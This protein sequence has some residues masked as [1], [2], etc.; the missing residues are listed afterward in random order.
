MKQHTQRK[1]DN[2]KNPVFI[3]KATWMNF[4]QT[5]DTSG[6]VQ[7]HPNEVWLKYS[8]STSEQ[9]S[10]LSL[11]KGRK[12]MQPSYDANLPLK[13]PNGHQIKRKKV[14]DLKRMIPFLP[15]KHRQFYLDLEAEESDVTDSDNDH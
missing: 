6:K 9:W 8:Y 10:K 14:D 2:D 11:L 15:I 1:K 5:I 7:R 12:K 4:G 13:Y 3:S